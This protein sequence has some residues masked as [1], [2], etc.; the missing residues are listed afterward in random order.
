MK[1][2]IR[3]FEEI[4]DILFRCEITRFADPKKRF[5]LLSIFK[6]IILKLKK[7]EGYI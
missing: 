7:L 4:Y 3:A 1:R 5:P 6:G 2:K